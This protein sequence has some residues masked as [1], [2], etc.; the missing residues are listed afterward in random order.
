MKSVPP[1]AVS[2][3]KILVQGLM[4]VLGRVSIK[5]IQTAELVAS[6]TASRLKDSIEGSPLPSHLFTDD[7]LSY[8]RGQKLSAAFHP[9]LSHD[10]RVQIYDCQALLEPVVDIQIA[11]VIVRCLKKKLPVQIS[12]LGRKGRRDLVISPHRLVYVLDRWH[13]RAVTHEIKN[14]FKDFV[15]SRIEDA[16]VLEP[17]SGK[18]AAVDASSRRRRK[19]DLKSMPS[20]IYKKDLEWHQIAALTFQLNPDLSNDLSAMTALEWKVQ[21]GQLRS[22]QVPLPNA[23]YVVRGVCRPMSSGLPRWLPADAITT[24]FAEELRRRTAADN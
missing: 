15:L 3:S 23:I 16:R 2:R 8:L 9:D 10:I 21:F 19:L 6:G 1:K 5:D 17:L 18:E 20:F 14:P 24:G 4:R 22:V 11:A 13:V 12:Y 7:I